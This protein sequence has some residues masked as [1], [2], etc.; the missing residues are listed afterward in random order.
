M[1]RTSYETLI[2]HDVMMRTSVA[3]LRLSD[4][5]MCTASD[6]SEISNATAR[7]VGMAQAHSFDECMIPS[8]LFLKYLA[9][10]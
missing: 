9:S 8:E 2:R 5:F 7:N 6:L 1:M 3:E 10:P 4:F